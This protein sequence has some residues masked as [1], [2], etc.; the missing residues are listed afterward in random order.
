[1]HNLKKVFLGVSLPSVTSA[2]FTFCCH[3]AGS[4]QLSVRLP[5]VSSVS[6]TGPRSS[7]RHRSHQ[8]SMDHKKRLLVVQNQTGIPFI[9]THAGTPSHW[10][11]GSE[12]DSA[13]AIHMLP[14]ALLLPTPPNPVLSFSF[15]QNPSHPSSPSPPPNSSFSS[16]FAPAAVNSRIPV[17]VSVHPSFFSPL[18][19]LHPSILFFHVCSAVKPSW[20]R[21]ASPVACSLC[22]CGSKTALNY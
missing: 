12:F 17:C 15:P 21:P 14:S 10:L 7:E 11:V 4:T 19:P 9:G 2:V 5:A 13:N 20:I 16:P 1:M 18:S 8:S 3:T 6:F 22:W